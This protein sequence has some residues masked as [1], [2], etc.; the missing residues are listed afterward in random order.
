MMHKI[1]AGIVAVESCFVGGPSWR[2][3]VM[4]HSRRPHPELHFLCGEALDKILTID[5][6]ILR[7]RIM[8]HLHCMC[9]RKPKNHG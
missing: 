7:W 8:V 6:M 9:K 5:N 2:G 1:R 3:Y 4:K